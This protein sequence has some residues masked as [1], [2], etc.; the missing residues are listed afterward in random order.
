MDHQEHHHWF[1]HQVIHALSRTFSKHNKY[2]SLHQHEEIIH[3]TERTRNQ[4]METN[5]RAGLQSEHK[6]RSVKP[7]IR[8]PCKKTFDISEES[9]NYATDYSCNDKATEV[10]KAQLKKINNESCQEFGREYDSINRLAEEEFVIA[11]ELHQENANLYKKA[12]K[13]LRQETDKLMTQLQEEARQLKTL[14]R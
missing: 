3:G 12:K 13:V 14:L 1:M 10:P 5:Y 6:F 9:L 7:V 4:N 8:N 2:G 11:K